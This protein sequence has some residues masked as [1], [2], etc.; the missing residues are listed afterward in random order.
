M[1]TLPSW[2]SVN[3]LGRTAVCC[4][5][6]FRTTTVP[7]WA[8]AAAGPMSNVKRRRATT[9]MSPLASSSRRIRSSLPHRDDRRWRCHRPHIPRSGERDGATHTPVVL[10][11]SDNQLAHRSV[12]VLRPASRLRFQ[13]SVDRNSTSYVIRRGKAG[14]RTS[15]FPANAVC[16]LGGPPRFSPRSDRVLRR[17]PQPRPPQRLLHHQRRSRPKRPQP[18][19]HLSRLVQRHATR[20]SG[21]RLTAGPVNAI[22]PHGAVDGTAVAGT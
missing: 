10:S 9:P 18:D 2:A 13:I 11:R 7:E 5:E 22:Q 15:V 1:P 12:Y 20:T 19:G 17:E 16:F 21:E 4:V 6:G 8:A 14:R 3:D